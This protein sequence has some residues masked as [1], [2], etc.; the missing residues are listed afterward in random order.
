MLLKSPRK[1]SLLRCGK[2]CAPPKRNRFRSFFVQQCFMY[3]E[4]RV[5]QMFV[6]ADRAA[7]K[8]LFVATPRDEVRQ[9]TDYFA[10]LCV[11]S[12]ALVNVCVRATMTNATEPKLKTKIASD[13]TD[14]KLASTKSKTRLTLAKKSFV[15]RSASASGGNG[16]VRRRERLHYIRGR[17]LSLAHPAERT[18]CK[19]LFDFYSG[20]IYLFIVVFFLSLL[21]F[22]LI[23]FSFCVEAK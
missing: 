7:K 6:S 22:Y 12:C 13:A 18:K 23:F 3:L 2:C 4:K 15:N 14:S 16:A 11:L 10:G 9:S 1:H 19:R 5:Q 17:S 20:K 8:P 21:H